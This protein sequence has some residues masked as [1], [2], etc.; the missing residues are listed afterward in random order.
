MGRIVRC[1]A[2]VAICRLSK[3]RRHGS[4]GGVAST[5]ASGSFGGRSIHSRLL[6]RQRWTARTGL[7]VRGSGFVPL[8][9]GGSELVVD[10]S[11]V[12]AVIVV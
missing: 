6:L 8:W 3:I 4:G 1:M 9:I 12:G 10:G 7:W 2:A 11:R 5:A